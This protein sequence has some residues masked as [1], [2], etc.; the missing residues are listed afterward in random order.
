M[1]MTAAVANHKQQLMTPGEAEIGHVQI[2]LHAAG[3][4]RVDHVGAG[5]LP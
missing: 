2:D 5:F 4:V 3:A 1:D